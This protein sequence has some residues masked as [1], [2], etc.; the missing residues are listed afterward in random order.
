MRQRSPRSCL[1]LAF[2]LWAT[3]CGDPAGPGPQVVVDADAAADDVPAL[4]ATADA[5]APDALTDAAATDAAA[6]LAGTDAAEPG[7]DAADADAAVEAADD[8]TAADD[9]VDAS[10]DA[11]VPPPP[12]STLCDPC[13]TNADCQKLG[14]S[15]ALCI[16]HGDT[17][18]FCGAGCGL[19]AAVDPCAP[20]FNCQKVGSGSAAQCMPLDGL[21]G[22]CSAQAVQDG[23]TTACSVTTSAGACAGKRVCG[24]AG[25]SACDAPTPATETCNGL[26]DNCNGQTDEGFSDLDGDGIADCVDPDIDGDGVANAADCSPTNAAIHPGATEI[27]NGIDDNCDGVTDVGDNLDGCTP[28]FLD[29]DGDSYGTGESVCRCLAFAPYTAAVAGDCNDANAAIH[30]GAPELC[31]GVDDNCDGA[32]DV[33]ATD[34]TKWYV[35]GDNDSYGAGDPVCACAPTASHTVAKA[36]DCDDSSGAIHPGA[37]ELCNGIDDNCDGVTD[38]PGAKGCTNFHADVD[39]DGY[40]DPAS[41]ACLCAPSG[42][43]TVI[44]STDC[45]DTKAT[46]YFGAPELCDGIDNNCNGLTD[47]AGATGCTVY[48]KDGDGDGYGAG[49]GACLCQP[50]AALNVTIGTDCD[51]S[52]AKIHPG[53]AEF[54]GGVDTDC[55]GLVNEPGAG[56]CTLF[57]RDHD[58]DGY[59]LASDTT[60]LCLAAGEYTTVDTTDCDDNASAVHPGAAEICNGIDDNCDGLTDPVGSGGCY[61]VYTDSDGDGFGANGPGVCVCTFGAGYASVH[62]DCNDADPSIHP[63]ATE[64]CNG[65]DDNCDGVTDPINSAGCLNY[66]QDNDADGY[67]QTAKKECL[68]LSAP[69]YSATVPGDCNDTSSAVNP[70][71]SEV[72]NGVDDNCNGQTDEGVTQ[73][74]YTDAD[75]DG[76]GAGIPVASCT[77]DATHTVLINGDCDDTRASAHPGAAEVCNGLDDNCNG[78]TDEGLAK[79]TWY[80]DADNDGFGGASWASLCGPNATYKVA[81][82]G[83]CNDANAAIHPGAPELCNGVDDNCDGAIDEGYP[84]AAYFH[85]GDGDG[86]GAGLASQQCGPFLGYTV[87]VS[88]D[89]NDA[90]SSVHPGATETCGNGLDDNC[91]GQTDEGCSTCVAQ[92]LQDFETGVATGWTTTAN[93]AAAYWLPITGTYALDYG[94]PSACGYPI[95]SAETASATIA[96]P[97]GAKFLKVNWRLNNYYS[98]TTTDATGACLT[99]TMDPTAKLTLKLGASSQQ[100]GPSATSLSAVQ[101]A[102]WAILPAQWGTSVAF[103]AAFTSTW[104]SSDCDGGAAIDDIRITCN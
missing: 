13:M 73:L 87:L 58:G 8:A 97:T 54:C 27:C 100:F 102:T 49:A 24:S 6:D 96:I 81:T 41:S 94:Y 29:A 93:W 101:T 86:Y 35:D 5:A 21:C 16:S 62:T 98:C 2:A 31:N 14:D 46:V 63:G 72:C 92:T 38:G 1:A 90:N 67:G 70:G 18:S 25:L 104:G 64:S 34:C 89:C 7:T 95:A 45:D 17:G 48:F 56:G 69:P 55:N 68:C 76:Y 71:A 40:G 59:G 42:V 85:D 23:A 57:A 33:S 30:P 84:V 80:M 32:T 3:A 60:C 22:G 50:T 47:E 83:D 77:G 43:F 9:A 19:N 26:D 10:A 28:H 78:Q 39:G 74:F 44:N 88:G 65:K 20:G 91:N 12:P 75:Q 36:G 37:P 52:N 51:D 79:S 61:T 53:A 11:D 103:S 4:D 82:T 99:Y 66:Y 15:E